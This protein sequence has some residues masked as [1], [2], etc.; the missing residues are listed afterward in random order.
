[1]FSSPKRKECEDLAE[2]PPGGLFARGSIPLKY[3]VDSKKPEGKHSHGFPL[4][5]KSKKR[6]KEVQLESHE[7]PKYG[8][9]MW[10]SHK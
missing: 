8:E 2:N 3:F 9:C 10:K 6:K 7:I 4:G 5:A 1:M